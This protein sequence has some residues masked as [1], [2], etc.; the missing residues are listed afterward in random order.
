MLR[1]LGKRQE[2]GCIEERDSELRLEGQHVAAE[3]KRLSWD[4]V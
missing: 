1:L 2:S 4:C 3:E